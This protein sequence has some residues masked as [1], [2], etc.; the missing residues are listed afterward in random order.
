M[1][2]ILSI[3]K[4]ETCIFSAFLEF[5]YSF[6]FIEKFCYSIKKSRLLNKNIIL[7]L[8]ALTIPLDISKTLY[9]KQTIVPGVLWNTI[10]SYFFEVYLFDILFI[11]LLL[12][13]FRDIYF[14]KKIY[15]SKINLYV[16]GFVL[17]SIISIINSHYFFESILALLILIKGYLIFLYISNNLNEQTVKYL[18]T[19]LISGIVLVNIIALF[20]F[21]KS[22]DFIFFKNPRLIF[23]LIDFIV[24]DSPSIFAPFYHPNM[25]G[26]FLVMVLPLIF[27]G[28]MRN[29]TVKLYYSKLLSIKSNKA[30]KLSYLGLLLITLVIVILTG[31]RNALICSILFFPLF[32]IINKFNIKKLFLVLIVILLILPFYNP[33]IMSVIGGGMVKAFED[34][35]SMERSRLASDGVNL[36]KTHPLIGIGLGSHFFPRY[37]NDEFLGLRTHNNLLY[38]AVETGIIGLLMFS[39]FLYSIFRKGFVS[40]G[41]RDNNYLII[42]A[43]MFGLFLYLI[44]GQLDMIIEPRIKALFW[45]F[46]GSIIGLTR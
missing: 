26:L 44:F 25:L 35:S 13:W 45:L 21:L 37:E 4:D 30:T 46:C 41:R 24:G 43:F 19:G 22:P 12:I 38:I 28:I 16:L 7:F 40:I 6:K 8:F 17:W 27:I 20:S 18:S 10:Q 29:K 42:N 39:L 31:S 14:N 1:S 33:L 15:F 2:K 32:Y 36:I 23:K 3:N 11:L 34:L 5:I 9:L